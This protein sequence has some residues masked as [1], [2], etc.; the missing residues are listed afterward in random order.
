MKK[1]ERKGLPEM[2]TVIMW[3][4][5]FQTIFYILTSFLVKWNQTRLAILQL[6]V[7]IRCPLNIFPVTLDVDLPQ[8]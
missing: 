7:F 5:S 8:S 3:L 1:V 2:T 6:P 4:Y